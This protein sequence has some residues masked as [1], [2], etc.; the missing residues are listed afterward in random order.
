MRPWRPY[1]PVFCTTWALTAVYVNLGNRA[2]LG[3]SLVALAPQPFI[4]WSHRR[5][6]LAR[7]VR[8]LGAPVDLVDAPSRAWVVC[9]DGTRVDCTLTRTGPRTWQARPVRPVGAVEVA[10]ALVDRLPDQASVVIDHS[11]TEHTK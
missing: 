1:L 7:R 9:H 10:A 2:G 3:I 5:T 11:T 4:W 8:E 6:H